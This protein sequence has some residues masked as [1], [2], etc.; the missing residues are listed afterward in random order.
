MKEWVRVTMSL[1]PT[2][3]SGL[4]V[5]DDQGRAV[6]QIPTLTG[7]QVYVMYVYKTFTRQE[8]SQ[9]FIISTQALFT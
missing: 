9:D 5:L 8:T 6:W 7:S 3:V 4:L 1:Q 2:F